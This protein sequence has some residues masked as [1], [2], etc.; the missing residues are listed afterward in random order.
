M[1]GSVNEYLP[2]TARDCGVNALSSRDLHSGNFHFP[3]MSP[4]AQTTLEA[5]ANVPRSL[6]P[7]G[8]N[9]STLHSNADTTDTSQLD[10]LPAFSIQERNSSDCE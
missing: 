7:Y 9:D 3:P 10:D 2:L 5:Y 1:T 6:S 8:V 4:R